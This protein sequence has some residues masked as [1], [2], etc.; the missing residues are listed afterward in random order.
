[1]IQFDIIRGH[2]LVLW[3]E[4]LNFQPEF[5][6][7]LDK[8]GTHYVQAINKS[9]VDEYTLVVLAKI[10]DLDSPFAITFK[11]TENEL[12]SLV[13]KVQTEPIDIGET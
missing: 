5:V 9:D 1:M 4:R 3:A 7:Q 12:N 2:K 6:Q 13:E 10:R 8:F 11:C